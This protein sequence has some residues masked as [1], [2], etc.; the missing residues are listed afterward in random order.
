MGGADRL[1]GR[2]GGAD[3][4]VF[5]G[6][7]FGLDRVLGFAAGDA[8]ADV[9]AMLDMPTSRDSFAEIYAAA[10]QSGANVLIGIDADS[11]IVL[12]GVQK[13]DLNAADFDFLG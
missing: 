7:D 8:S 10:R 3:R 12:Y 4:F 6:S 2:S 5:R 11:T 9:L 13:T 1:D